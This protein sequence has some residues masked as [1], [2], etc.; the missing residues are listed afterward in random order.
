MMGRG[1]RTQQE[2][3]NWIAK[4]AGKVLKILQEIQDPVTHVRS[5]QGKSRLGR[6]KRAHFVIGIYIGIF[7]Q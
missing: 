7:Y 2:Y 6:S 5:P 3:T 4:P 1:T